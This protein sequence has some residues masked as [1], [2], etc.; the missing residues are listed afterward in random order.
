MALPRKGAQ[1]R[2]PRSAKPPKNPTPPPG[3]VP[4]YKSDP[5]LI[6]RICDNLELGMPIT[7]AAE[8]EGVARSTMYEWMDDKTEQAR[9]FDI[10]GRVT[11][12][13]AAGAKNLVV[14]SL[15]GGPGSG[16]ATWHLERR[17]HQ[18]YGVPK[19]DPVDDPGRG[20][21]RIV[22]EGGLPRRSA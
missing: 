1:A 3:P 15:K 8:A 18:D 14:R 13:R 5:K 21:V 2:K 10:S 17:Y 16:Q 4:A 19:A 12:A 7:L 20:E 22:I 6:D 9:P 11:R